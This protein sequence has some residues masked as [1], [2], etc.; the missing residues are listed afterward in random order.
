MQIGNTTSILGT[1]SQNNSI[2]IDE[3]SS[4]S[5][6]F[7]VLLENKTKEQKKTEEESLRKQLLDE[8]NFV[9]KTGFTKEELEEIKKILEELAK[10]RAESGQTAQTPEEYIKNLKADLQYAVEKVT[11]KRMDFNEDMLSN[12]VNSQNSSSQVLATT[13]TD[14]EL[15]LI[16]DL[17]QKK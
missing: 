2:N 16:G 6:E 17:K 8:L 5:N 9:A 11:G 15:R 7:G 14:E 3:N 10:Q 13:S 1:T 12:F 4:S